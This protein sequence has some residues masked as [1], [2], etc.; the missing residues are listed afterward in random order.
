MSERYS[1]ATEKM[2]NRYPSKLVAYVREGREKN[3]AIL[4]TH[5]AQ[6]AHLVGL[7]LRSGGVSHTILL[8]SF[9][10]PGKFDNID[11]I[12]RIGRAMF[13]E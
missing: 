3:V 1:L 4:G 9:V 13:S 8:E 7:P 11:S 10:N 12:I 6:L 2:F 5:I